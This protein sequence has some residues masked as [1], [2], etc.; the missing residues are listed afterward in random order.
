MLSGNLFCKRYGQISGARVIDGSWGVIFDE[1]VWE[2]EAEE[3]RID[4]ALKSVSST[5]ISTSEAYFPQ[6]MNGRTHTS[7]LS[8]DLLEPRDSIC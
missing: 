4:M 7:E 5:L 6:K 8:K 2:V 1:R 3:V